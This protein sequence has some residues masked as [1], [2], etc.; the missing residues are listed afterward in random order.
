[1]QS[2]TLFS[3]LAFAIGD[4]EGSRG[5]SFVSSSAR[6]DIQATCPWSEC[7]RDSPACEHFKGHDEPDSFKIRCSSVHYIKRILEL[8]PQEYSQREIARIVARSHGHINGIFATPFR[9]LS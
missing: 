6:P 1:M 7:E 5:V 3:C 9:N 2:S 8:S 4:G